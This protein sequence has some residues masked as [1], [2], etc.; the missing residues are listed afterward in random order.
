[1]SL[2][3]SMLSCLAGWRIAEAKIRKVW[4]LTL[5]CATG[6]RDLAGNR[7]ENSSERRLYALPWVIALW[8]SLFLSQNANAA[9]CI[10]LFGIYLY[11]SFPYFTVIANHSEQGGGAN[12]WQFFQCHH[13]KQCKLL[14]LQSSSCSAKVIYLN[15]AENISLRFWQNCWIHYSASPIIEIVPSSLNWVTP[16]KVGIVESSESVNLDECLKV[17]SLKY[18]IQNVTGC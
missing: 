18:S 16:K 15:H 7:L 9:N 6:F 8:S 14:A 3:V 2:S 11:L 13:D 10:C 12:G 4:S 17:W 5:L 1:M